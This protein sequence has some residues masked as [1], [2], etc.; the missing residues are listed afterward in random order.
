MAKYYYTNMISALATG[1]ISYRDA[2]CEI[3]KR[4]CD[5]ENENVQYQADWTETDS[6]S[7]SYIQ[8][9][10]SVQ[11]FQAD[12]NETNSTA[13]GY[14]QNKPEIVEQVQSDWTETDSA[15]P[16]YI[17]HKPSVQEFQAD[18]NE[19]NSTAYGYIQNKPSIPPA[20]VQSD[21]NIS[22]AENLAYIK[23]KPS[24]P[25][26]PVQSDW[27][28]TNTSSLAYIK[29]KPSL[30]SAQVQS[31]WTETDSTSPSYIQHK[32]SVQEF[33]ADWNETNSTAYGYIQN[34][35]EI[36]EQVQSDWTE[37]DASQVSFIKNKPGNT[38]I[39]TTSGT[40]VPPTQGVGD[41]AVLLA[42]GSW[43]SVHSNYIE[44]WPGIMAGEITYF[45][46]ALRMYGLYP[47]ASW[48]R[49]TQCFA[50]HGTLPAGATN[51]WG[52]Q[53]VQEWIP[54]KFWHFHGWV[55][56]YT[57]DNSRVTTP[58][59]NYGINM[60]SVIEHTDLTVSD[61]YQAY[62][63]GRMYSQSKK[64]VRYSDSAIDPSDAFAAL[65]FTEQQIGGVIELTYDA[66]AAYPCLGR[67]CAYVYSGSTMELQDYP[68]AQ[69]KPGFI[70]FEIWVNA[71]S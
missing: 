32:P 26:A 70:E 6:A 47:R 10:P 25:P 53:C 14:I 44:W 55:C 31:D 16:S 22:D 52:L 36:V 63:S 62:T 67:H 35:P 45:T 24:I 17:Q 15:S 7:P 43:G 9:K 60:E 68:L 27:T 57:A 59:F 50:Y 19:T 23:N 37:T 13:Y 33:Q 2:L 40:L 71:E 8:H 46:N 4:L 48:S 54:G 11:E 12:W 41:S 20:P 39:N 49:Y 56:L 64:Y 38:T 58:F 5:L 66:D 42:N 1:Q 30:P 3:L 51:V 61:L 69:Q 29:N 18:W 21:W 34:K 65:Q 28:E